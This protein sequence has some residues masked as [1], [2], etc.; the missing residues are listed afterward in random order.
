[1]KVLRVLGRGRREE[2]GGGR[3]EGGREEGKGRKEEGGGRASLRW[4]VRSGLMELLRTLQESVRKIEES[5]WPDFLG[6][7]KV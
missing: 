6:P 4:E 2:E 7:M 3:R 5:R 1:M